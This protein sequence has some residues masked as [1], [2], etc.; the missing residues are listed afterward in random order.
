MMEGSEKGAGAGPFS[1]RTEDGRRDGL[2]VAAI[3]V[4]SG[5]LYLVGY[6]A[7]R[8]IFLNGQG[9]NV[10]GEAVR[11]TPPDGERLVLELGAYWG[12]T[13][14]LF[15]LYALILVLCRRGVLRDGRA[16]QL[17]LAFPV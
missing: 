15:L 9:A 1:E 3:G 12:I 14:A 16:A 13:A 17:A 11:G 5:A 8:A 10:A 4:M 7:Q 2:R 6:W